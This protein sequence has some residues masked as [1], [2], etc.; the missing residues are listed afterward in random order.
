M[1]TITDKG[2]DY[3]NTME[4]R[5]FDSK[6]PDSDSLDMVVLYV[7]E[8]EDLESTDWILARVFLFEKKIGGGKSS[9]SKSR[10]EDYK[11]SIRRLF[12]AGHIEEY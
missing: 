9:I 12:E 10:I 3:L 5:I 11:N 7:L 4:Q 2:R 8:E 6:A 1:L